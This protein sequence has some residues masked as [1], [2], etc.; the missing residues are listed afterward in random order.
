MAANLHY[1]TV[2]DILWINFQVTEKVHHFSFAK[3][4]EA[5]Y[6]QYGYGESRSLVPQAA[7]FLVGFPKLH[8]LEAGNDATTFI[9][10]LTFLKING[11]IVDLQDA[12]ALAWYESVQSR[13][14]DAQAAI[15]SIAKPFLGH[16]DAPSIEIRKIVNDLLSSYP[17]TL[18]N[19]SDGKASI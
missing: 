12:K 19:L 7:R 1:L 9:A 6:Y 17:C 14:V 3:L 11:L 4:E 15:Q 13:A 8:P 18:L 16:H 5:T 10:C 2:Q